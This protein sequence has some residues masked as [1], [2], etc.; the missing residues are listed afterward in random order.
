MPLVTEETL[1]IMHIPA[2]AQSIN[3]NLLREG[4]PLGIPGVIP[5]GAEG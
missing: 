2:S 1:S 5:E 3:L 4:Q